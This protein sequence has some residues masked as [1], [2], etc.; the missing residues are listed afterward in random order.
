MKPL[1]SSIYVNDDFCVDMEFKKEEDIEIVTASLMLRR[2]VFPKV[3]IKSYSTAR[4]T[5]DVPDKE[6][7]RNR[8]EMVAI[9]LDG[10][11]NW[12]SVLSNKVRT[13]KEE[14]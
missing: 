6:I 8:E 10:L 4:I 12:I 2:G 7:E 11:A 14:A 1:P 13:V 5:K 9:A 3:F